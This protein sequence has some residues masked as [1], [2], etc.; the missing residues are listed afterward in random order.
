MNQ[1]VS[2]QEQWN[3]AAW[4]EYLESIHHRPIDMGLERVRQVA[5]KLAILRP[6]A[7]VI[8][9]GG[10]NGKGSTVR[11]LEQ[12]LLAAG[13][14]VACYTSPHIQHYNERV[15]V[16]GA[17]LTDAEHA[18]AMLAI[19][20]ARGDISLTYFEFGTLAAIWL[21]QQ[22]QPQVIL[23]EVGLGG[24][25][26]AVNIIDPDVAIVT[27]V[28]IDHVEFLG[29]NREDI[30]FEKAGIFRPQRP[31]IC[32]D[33]QPPQRLLRHAEHIGAQLY[34]VGGDYQASKGVETFE[35]RGPRQTWQNLPMPQLPFANALTA[36][37]ALQ[38]SGLTVPLT[39]VRAGLASA[40]LPGRMQVLQQQPLVVADVAH[41]PHAAAY[42][43][44]EL[45]QRYPGK[46]IVA[47]CGMLRDKDCAGSLAALAPIVQQWYLASLPEPRGASAAV[48]AA[49][50]GSS[51]NALQFN[52]VSAA[53]TQAAADVNADDVIVCFGS[54]VTVAAVQACMG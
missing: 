50:L 34:C 48:L 3:L 17:V 45:G 8:T 37:A 13:Y 23:L 47:I 29:D 38:L 44:T 5:E 11:Y 28:G 31:A 54:F 1:Q 4:L 35:F 20:R 22:L 26:D 36:L 15:R 27:S 10:T 46:R 14:S 9:V 6:Q 19:E 16:N 51:A 39:A 33:S 25:L 53:F 40:Q 24:R 52:T 30:G 7:T 43:A 49:A 18:Q 2:E 42:L 32:G 12:I 41:N 21:C